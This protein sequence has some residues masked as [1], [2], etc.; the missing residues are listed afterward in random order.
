MW[1]AENIVFRTLTQCIF[2]FIIARQIPDLLSASIS[3]DVEFSIS[4]P[5]ME[6]VSLWR[7][8]LPTA[9]VAHPHFSPRHVVDQ[10]CRCSG[11]RAPR[12]DWVCR[13]RLH[14]TPSL[15]APLLTEEKPTA[16]NGPSPSTYSL[17]LKNSPG[18]SD[19]LSVSGIP[20]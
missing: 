1:Q 19:S 8:P 2:P 9:G 5:F 3:R 15:L 4:C 12:S 11:F 7:E 18:A 17:G 20:Q 6:T 10:A 13:L 14:G 16:V